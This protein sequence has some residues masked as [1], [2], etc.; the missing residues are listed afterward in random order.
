[1]RGARAAEEGA[2]RHRGNRPVGRFLA[3]FGPLPSNVDQKKVA[4]EY[5][6]GVL[7]LHLPKRTREQAGR[8]KI[9]IK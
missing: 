4:A 6:D 8:V 2:R 9:E 5:K 3:H 7:K 1:V